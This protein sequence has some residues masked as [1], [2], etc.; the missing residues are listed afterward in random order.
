MNKPGKP[1]A[2]PL[3]M[4]AQMANEGD[5]LREIPLRLIHPDPDQPR[6]QFG[7][8]EDELFAQGIKETGLA[9]PLLVRPHPSLPGEYMIAVGE[10][11]Y[12]AAEKAG[13][14]TVLCQIRTDFTPGLLAILQ[15]AENEARKSLTELE[16]AH[17]MRRALDL[18]PSLSQAALARQLGRH[19]SYVSQHLSLLDPQ[20]VSPQTR[21]AVEAGRLSGPANALAFEALP[22]KQREELL[23]TDKPIRRR[24]LEAVAATAPP[25]LVSTDRPAAPKTESRASATAAPEPPRR[26][27]GRPRSERR[28]AAALIWTDWIR[29]FQKLG[30]EPPASPDD[31]ESTLRN[32]LGK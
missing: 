17:G 13:Y 20:R 12:H 7:G 29:L 32:L 9:Q 2:S 19:P 1:L 22:H 31:L 8:E 26:S 4:L 30:A 11:R 21:A 10:R 16:R 5:Q 24:D 23:A 25:R 15:L 18:N 6:R 3:D 28:I 14:D 27:A